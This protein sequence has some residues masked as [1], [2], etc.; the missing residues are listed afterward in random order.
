MKTAGFLSHW[1]SNKVTMYSMKGLVKEASS[2]GNLNL[3]NVW[4][5]WTL[6]S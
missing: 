4:I 6:L 3:D 1:A 5:I 2:L